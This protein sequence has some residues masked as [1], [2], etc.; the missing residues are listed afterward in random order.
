[1]KILRLLVMSIVPLIP[2]VLCVLIFY[3][4]KFEQSTGFRLLVIFSIILFIIVFLGAFISYIYLVTIDVS[5]NKEEAFKLNYQ[6]RL[7]QL[8]CM[9]ISCL[10]GVILLITIFTFMVGFLIFGYICF[11]TFVN[12]IVSSILVTICRKDFRS[13]DRMITNCLCC[14]IYPLDILASRIIYK[15]Y[16]KNKEEILKI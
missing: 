5:N 15:D 4:P 13:K 11:I 9:L 16:I 1:M 10:L 2:T 6:I 3:A 12:A 8:P 7:I 14:F